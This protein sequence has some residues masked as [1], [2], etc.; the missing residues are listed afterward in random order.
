MSPKLYLRNVLETMEGLNLS[1]LS[2]FLQAHF[3]EGN[4]PHFYSQLT[5]MAQL[6]DET[7]YYFA[8]LCLEMHQKVIVASKQSHDI[9]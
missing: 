7:A 9:A 4:S 8:I 6:S 5:S 1:T 2:R 3:Q